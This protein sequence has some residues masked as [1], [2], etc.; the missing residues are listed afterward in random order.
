MVEVGFRK[1]SF[2]AEF[3]AIPE[4]FAGVGWWLYRGAEVVVC[5]LFGFV[6]VV[7]PSKRHGFEHVVPCS[8]AWKC[9]VEP[10]AILF[11]EMVLSLFTATSYKGVFSWRVTNVYNVW[12]GYLLFSIGYTIL[13]VDKSFYKAPRWSF[14]AWMIA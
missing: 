7:E 8:P 2:Y 4:E 9:W 6:K 1:G 13:S 3:E 11:S 14:I 10:E 12:F 5:F